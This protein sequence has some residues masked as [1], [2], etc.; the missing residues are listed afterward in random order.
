VVNG[1]VQ[2]HEASSDKLL[3]TLVDDNPSV[4]SMAFSPSDRLLATGEAYNELHVWDTS[5]GRVVHAFKGHFTDVSAVAF[6]PDGRTLASGG[7]D[8]TVK[9]WNVETAQEMVSYHFPHGYVAT[10]EFASSGNA[11]GMHF[12]DSEE[13][14]EYWEA[15]SLEEIPS[16]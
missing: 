10:V 3:F 2:L 4:Y 7:S 5:T 6:S 1:K 13:S 11:L 16:Q 8:G 12:R 15:P 14:V 9:L